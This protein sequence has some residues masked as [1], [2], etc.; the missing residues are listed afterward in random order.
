MLLYARLASQDRRAVASVWIALGILVAVVVGWR[1][2]SVAEIVTT[3]VAVS[4]VLTAA[5]LLMDVRNS[6]RSNGERRDLVPGSGNET[7]V[8]IEAAE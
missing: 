6:V 2:G 4:L 8:P 7:V 3:V 5:G 1:H